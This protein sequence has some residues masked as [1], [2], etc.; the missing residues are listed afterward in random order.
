M[1]LPYRCAACEDQP[2]RCAPCRARRAAAT[3]RARAAKRDA[4]VC[5]E[6]SARAQPGFS[7]CKRHRADNNTRSGAAHAAARKE[8]P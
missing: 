5:T 4:G 2:A 1:A 3:Q 7:R 8:S 6:C